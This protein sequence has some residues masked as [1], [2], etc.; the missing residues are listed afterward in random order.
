MEEMADTL[1]A[2]QGT[3]ASAESRMEALADVLV[4]SQEP[5]QPMPG[6][7]PKSPLPE[8]EPEKEEGLPATLEEEGPASPSPGSHDYSAVIIHKHV[9]TRNGNL[10][11]PFEATLL[12][13]ELAKAEDGKEFPENMT[14]DNTGLVCIPTST[15]SHGKIPEGIK[16]V[17]IMIRLPPDH[18]HRAGARLNWAEHMIQMC[19]SGQPTVY[20]IGVTTNPVWRL[21]Q[22]MKENMYDLMHLIDYSTLPGWAPMLEAALIRDHIGRSGCQNVQ[23]GGEGPGSETGLS[24]KHGVAGGFIYIVTGDAG[25][26]VLLGGRKKKARTEQTGQ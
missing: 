1:L 9:W 6:A 4:P 12:D 10:V 14:G 25:A 19:I 23:T 15:A 22:Y 21:S 20:K 16:A 2:S 24:D 3:S 11:E 8:K 13:L 18:M 7:L 5:T 17:G 26:G